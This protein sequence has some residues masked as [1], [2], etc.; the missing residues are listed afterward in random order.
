MLDLLKKIEH[1]YGTSDTWLCA[2]DFYVLYNKGQRR[3][4]SEEYFRAMVK[5]FGKRKAFNLY[6]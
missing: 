6:I 4:I 2:T 5:K 1:S 3:M